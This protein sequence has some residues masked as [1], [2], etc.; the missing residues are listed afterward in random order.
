[1]LVVVVAHE[2]CLEG[3]EFAMQ[4]S[5]VLSCV[6]NI[7]SMPPQLFSDG[8]LGPPQNTTYSNS[9]MV[10]KILAIFLS[11][12]YSLPTVISKRS[13]GISIYSITIAYL[14]PYLKLAE[15]SPNPLFV[16]L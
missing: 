11:I 4:F 16:T 15:A 14:A 1:L 12:H 5:S 8:F 10:K 7:C 2:Q 6:V 9:T 3:Q 13:N